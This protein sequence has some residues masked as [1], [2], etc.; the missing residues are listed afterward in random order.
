MTPAQIQL[1]ATLATAWLHSAPEG[2]HCSVCHTLLR[3]TVM[4]RACGVCWDT[5]QVCRY[6]C[7]ACPCAH[8]AVPVPA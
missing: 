3:T 5:Q 2:P 1:W 4:L 8:P 7:P 6:L